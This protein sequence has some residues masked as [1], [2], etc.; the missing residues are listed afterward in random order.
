MRQTLG[1]ATFFLGLIT[2]LNGIGGVDASTNNFELL[3]STV[4]AAIG[5]GVMALGT[6]YFDRSAK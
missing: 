5:V 6:T 2:V 4:I 1:F 3:V